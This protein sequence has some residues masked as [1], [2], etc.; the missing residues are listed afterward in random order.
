[1]TPLTSDKDEWPGLNLSP[2]LQ[3]PATQRVQI[4]P[5]VIT[6][7]APPDVSSVT[8]LEFTLAD[9]GGG[10]VDEDEMLWYACELGLIVTVRLL[11]S[12]PHTRVP[13]ARARAQTRHS[14][15]LC[16]VRPAMA[17]TAERASP[18]LQLPARYARTSNST[19]LSRVGAYQSQVPPPRHYL[20]A[21]C[22][23]SLLHAPLPLDVTDIFDETNT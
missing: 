23:R 17:C 6:K 1:M 3:R 4:H 11:S 21:S 16:P 12:L 14:R 13:L 7:T 19:R 2:S 20:C 18:Y 10:R 9:P 15:T 5:L 22:L 8:A